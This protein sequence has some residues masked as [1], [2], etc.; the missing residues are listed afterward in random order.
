MTPIGIGRNGAAPKKSGMHAAFA[1]RSRR[2]IGRSCP[3][4]AMP[5]RYFDAGDGL[6]ANSPIRRLKTAGR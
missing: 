2:G 4:A 6:S 3:S 1:R 5:K